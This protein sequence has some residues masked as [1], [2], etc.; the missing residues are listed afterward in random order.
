MSFAIIET[1]GKQYKVSASKILEVEKLDAKIFT[2]SE[3]IL[4]WILFPYQWWLIS[5]R[6]SNRFIST[7]IACKLTITVHPG[8]VLHHFLSI[9]V[10]HVLRSFAM[11]RVV[12][13][14]RSARFTARNACVTSLLASDLVTCGRA[15]GGVTFQVFVKLTVEV[16][17]VRAVMQLY[18]CW[19]NLK[20][21]WF[22]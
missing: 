8:D 10:T 13:V 9:H 22:G 3:R 18:T 17:H 7:S 21:Y 20:A 15:G 19:E 6:P 14:I 16:T 11:A 5:D 1:G 12:T 4:H 2:H